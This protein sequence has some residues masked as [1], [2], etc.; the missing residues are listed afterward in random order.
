MICAC[1]ILCLVDSSQTLQKNKA[2]QK[3]AGAIARLVE[4]A[5]QPKRRTPTL[6][7]HT[8]GSSLV[9][10]PKVCTISGADC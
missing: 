8:L 9:L 5:P 10:G 6:L 7:K 4:I 3:P 2:K 1:G